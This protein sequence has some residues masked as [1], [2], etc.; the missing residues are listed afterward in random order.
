MDI[1]DVDGKKYYLLASVV[2]GSKKY[3][4]FGNVDDAYDQF[5]KIYENGEYKSLETDD[6]IEMAANLLLEK[7]ES[8]L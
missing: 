3:M 6:E 8:S 7:L 4:L 5:I 2:K 1:Y